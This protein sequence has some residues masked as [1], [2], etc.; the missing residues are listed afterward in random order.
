LRWYVIR[1][2][3]H[4]EQMA[5]T[6]LQ[7]QGITVFIPKTLVNIRHARKISIRRA[8]LFPG[9]GFVQ[10]DLS[11]VRWRSINGTYGVER[12]LMGRD[13]PLPVPDGVVEEMLAYIDDHGVVDLSRGLA[14]GKKVKI[15]YGPFS[16]LMG[17][18]TSL[19]KNGRIELLLQ[20]L[21]GEV[22]TSVNKDIL[23][24]VR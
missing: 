3:P 8:S 16:G 21:N 9:Y 14:V 23:E 4:L 19:D 18:L 6:N 12:L 13:M 2:L 15:R 17:T 22:L 5:E 20:M 24:P 1:T 7:R 11:T 10:L